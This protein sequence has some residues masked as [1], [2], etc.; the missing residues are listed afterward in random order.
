MR[1]HPPPMRISVLPTRAKVKRVLF[2][3]NLFSFFS[4][5]SHTSVLFLVVLQL[6]RLFCHILEMFATA[7][8]P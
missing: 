5:Y 1:L 6:V 3:W 4:D 7:F 2:H 8:T